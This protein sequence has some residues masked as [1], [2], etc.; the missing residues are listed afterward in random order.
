M[1]NHMSVFAAALIGITLL[2]ACATE[3]SHSTSQN[4]EIKTTSARTQSIKP[5]MKNTALVKNTIPASA[6]SHALPSKPDKYIASPEW[7]TSKLVY[8]IGWDKKPNSKHALFVS[9][10]AGHSWTKVGF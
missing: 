8:V 2:T 3:N 10:N 9:H 4:I 7:V 1:N 6:H 5:N